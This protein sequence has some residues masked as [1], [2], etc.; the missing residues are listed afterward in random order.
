MENLRKV[1]LVTG[2]TRGI[3][4]EIVYTLAENGY[5]VSVNYRTKTAEVEEMKK[6]IEEKFNVRCAVVQGDVGSFEDA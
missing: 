6:E 5:D 1:A 4:K 3:G 2:A